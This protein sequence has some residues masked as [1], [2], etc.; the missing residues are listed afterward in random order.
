MELNRKIDELKDE[1]II[2]TQDVLASLVNSF[3][4]EGLRDP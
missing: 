1:L 3:F 2:A 4:Y